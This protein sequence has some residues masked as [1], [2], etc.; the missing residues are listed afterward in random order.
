MANETVVTLIGNLT[1]DPSLR[2][3]PS[4][5]PVSNFTVAC[6]PRQFDK[7]SNE[8]RDGDTMFLRCSIWRK[9]AEN[10]AESLR[11]G[12]RVILQGRLRSRTYE[13]RETGQPRTVFEVEVDEVGPSLKFREIPHGRQVERSTARDENDPFAS[14]Q[15]EEPPF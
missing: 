2:F 11:K 3:T 13:D 10:V 14:P 6:T 15:T 4:G 7:A 1:D 5:A 8:W 9:P 12:D